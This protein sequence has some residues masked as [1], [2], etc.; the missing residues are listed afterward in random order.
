MVGQQRQIMQRMKNYEDK[1]LIMNNILPKILM[2][3][4]LPDFLDGIDEDNLLE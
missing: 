3:A 1:K 4:N 2:K